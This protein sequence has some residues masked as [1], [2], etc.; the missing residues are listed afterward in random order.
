MAMLPLP[1]SSL[2]LAG[3]PLFSLAAARLVSSASTSLT[4]VF[5]MDTG[6]PS[7]LSTPAS[8]CVLYTL[9]IE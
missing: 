1:Y 4:S 5:G 2:S 9:K 7:Y 6:V 8:K 3:I